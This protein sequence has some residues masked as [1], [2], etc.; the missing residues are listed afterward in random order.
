[1]NN[2]ILYY[3]YKMRQQNYGLFTLSLNFNGQHTFP[4]LWYD[5]MENYFLAING[6]ES[7]FS[8]RFL[9]MKGIVIW[10]N[11][12]ITYFMM[13][14]FVIIFICHILCIM[15]KTTLLATHVFKMLLNHFLEALQIYINVISLSHRLIKIGTISRYKVIQKV[16]NFFFEIVGTLNMGADGMPTTTKLTNI[17]TT[18]PL[19]GNR[20]QCLLYDINHNIVRFIPLKDMRG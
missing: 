2:Y 1:M 4:Q 13:I 9:P 3:Y 5:L 12:A 14:N 6:I 20:E 7:T 16:F 17:W 15:T 11:Y 19:Q 8:F 10:A 18:K